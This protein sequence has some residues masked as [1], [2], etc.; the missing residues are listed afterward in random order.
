MRM[1]ATIPV[2]IAALALSGPSAAGQSARASRTGEA[3]IRELRFN[4]ATV[5]TSMTAD[6]RRARSP[7]LRHPR[8]CVIQFA[9]PLD[10]D[11]KRALAAAGVKLGDYL[12][13]QAYA[14]RLDDAAVERLASMDRV[15]WIGRFDKSWKLDPE[16]GR[17]ELTSAARKALAARG[18]MRVLVTLFEGREAGPTIAAIL[19]IAGSRVHYTEQVSGNANILATIPATAAA[20][21]AELDDVQYVEEAPELTLRNNTTR[22][23]V[24]TNVVDATPFYTHGITGVGQIVGILD[25]RVDSNHCAF[26]D[27]NPIGPLHR[28]IL[29]YNTSLGMSSHGTFVAGV[30][31]GDAGAFD[32]NRGV[33]YG[34]KLVYNTYTS[35]FDET[36][37]YTN[38]TLHHNQGARIHTNSW[39]NDSS[40]SYDGLCRGIDAFC[41]DNEDDLV[42]FAVTNLG[43]LRNPENA[44]NLIAVGGCGDTPNQEYHCTGGTGP[45]ADGRRKPE[46]F[47]PG[48]GVSSSQSGTGCGVQTNPAGEGG[49]SYACPA[50]AGAALLVRQYFTD[51]FY[52]SG[53]ATPADALTPSGALVK[54]ALINSAVDMSGVAG[55]PSNQEGWGRVLADNACYFPGDARKLHL[56]A[57][58]RNAAGLST[59][60]EA[61]YQFAVNGSAQQLRLTL[62]WTDPPAAAST[63]TANAAVNDLDLEVTTPSSAVYLGNV[64]SGGV[65]VPGGTPDTKNNV[66][67]V[68]VSSPSPGIWTVKCKATAVNV[69]TQGFALI[70]TGEVGPVL[71]APTISSITPGSG[72]T[73][74]LVSI[75]DLSGTGFQAGASVSLRRTGHADIPAANVNVGSP[76]SITCDFDL[77]SAAVGTWDVVVTNVDTQSGVLSNGF[78]VTL[79]PPTVVSIAPNMATV[80]TI[81][82][83]TDL[84]GSDFQTGASVKLR[85]SGQPDVVAGSVVVASSNRITCV[86][87]LTG[88]ALGQWDVV[89]TNPDSQAATLTNGFAVIA[90]APSIASIIPA[91]GVRGTIVNISDLAGTAFQIGATVK[92]RRSGEADIGGQSV[93]V[94]SPNQITCTFDLT[95]AAVGLWDVVVTNPDAQSAT[96]TNGF[97]I[98]APA[99]SLNSITPSTGVRG[100]L[101]SVSDLAGSNFE[102]GATATLRRTGHGDIH[103]A[104]VNVVSPTQI[105]CE[106]DLSA[107]AVGQWD[108]VVTNPDAQA[109]TLPNGFTV[110]APAPTV[111]YLVPNSGQA[112]DLVVISDLHGTDFQTGASVK[113]VRSG[114]P[115]IDGG[116]VVVESAT[117]ITCTF[118]LAGAPIGQWDVVVTNPDMQSGLLP[119]G[120]TVYE[121][122]LKADMNDD[123]GV[124]G[125]DIQ[126]FIDFLISG[127]AGPREA[128]A[129]DVAAVRDNQ[130]GEDDLPAFVDCILSAGC[131]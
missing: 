42:L 47:A 94:A 71:P 24:Q 100:T 55:Y 117:K 53:S 98:V 78:A 95:G 7:A 130:I 83:I 70:A 1:K 126:R 29:A 107:A 105:T 85:K 97:T 64:F 54:A 32:N 23:I 16:L 119:G 61:Q 75:T 56:I 4:A 90:P 20:A 34:A 129:G 28:K 113:L 49:T 17:R 87:D 2:V 14:A 15:R 122:C 8:T 26:S 13:N 63:G 114:E 88:V 31:A 82:S 36:G 110:L 69:G 118:D 5:D 101:V 89:V 50:V 11:T 125:K 111:A 12:T 79:P 35:S 66:E 104:E 76:T 39:G 124:N 123:G 96:L 60:N 92:L 67:Q 99:P 30:V 115:D 19:A 72:Q 3:S 73:D 25:T 128:C 38:L 65:S 108:V 41:R 21:L 102:P 120:F 57:D 91:G 58:L 43:T 62:V 22:W 109:A 46:L 59:G 40:T 33:A 77:A 10:A 127:G 44:K 103:G 80:D 9:Q 45:T 37:I 74:T 18:Q 27:V 106:F 93:N 116:S 48:C 6:L 112:G 84:A 131:V 51:G 121:S 81:V 86:F 52:P 68:H